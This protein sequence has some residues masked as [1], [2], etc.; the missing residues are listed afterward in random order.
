MISRPR[1]LKII[2]PLGIISSFTPAVLANESEV[3]YGRDIRPILSD[4]CFFCHGPDPETREEGLR[5]DIREEALKGKA[6]VPGHPEKSALIKLINT[7]D[8]EKIM[9]P[10]KSHKKLSE[11]EKKLLSDWIKAGAEYEPHWAYQPLEMHKS[12]DKESIDSLVENR[13]KKKG[14]SFSEPAPAAT[15]LRRLHFDLTGLPPTPAEVVAFTEAHKKDPQQAVKDTAEKLLASPHFGERMAVKWLDA[16]RYADTVGYHGDQSRDASPFRD[17]VINSFN[18]DLPY[19]QF[20][21][22]QIAGDLLPD[23]TLT[24]QV[25][26]AYNRINQISE[27][28]GIQDEEYIAKYQAERV[29]TTSAA[30]L[31]STLACAECHDH[32]FDPFTAKDFYSFAAYFSDILEKGAWNNNGSYQED[33]KKYKKEGVLFSNYGPYLKVPD[34]ASGESYA[35]IEK[36]LADLSNTHLKAYP[37][38]ENAFQAWLTGLRQKPEKAN[39]VDVPFITSTLASKSQVKARKSNATFSY[40]TAD[41]GPVRS[42]SHSRKQAS[43]GSLTQHIF[44]PAEPIQIKAGEMLYAWV[45]LDPKSPPGSVMLQFYK[46]NEGWDHRAYWGENTIPYGKF[47][48]GAAYHKAGSLPQLGNWVRLEVSPKDL[49]LQPGTRVT[50]LAYT[51]DKGTV[52]WGSAGKKVSDQA[53]ILANMPAD[54]RKLINDPKSGNTLRGKAD[55]YQ[56]FLISTPAKTQQ[57]KEI[58]ALHAKTSQTT[59]KFRQVPATISAKRRVVRL[60][61]RGNWTDKSGPIVQ[62]AP[63]EFLTNGKKIGTSRLDLARWIAS[64]DNP[65]TARVFVNRVWSQFFGTGLSKSDGDFGL[66]GEY[67]SNPELLDWL[68]AEFIS[69]DWSVKELVRTIVRSKTYQQSSTPGGEFIKRDPKNRLLARQTQLRLPAELVRDNALAVSGLLNPEIGGASVYPYQP[70]GYYQ[71]LNF[72]KRQYPTSYGKDL[73]RRGIYTHWQRSF[74]HPMMKNFDAPSREECTT[75]RSE[76]NTPLQALTLLN[77]PTFTEAARALATKLLLQSKE[78][79]VQRA[80]MHSLSRKATEAEFKILSELYHTEL[81]RFQADPKA[82]ADFISIGKSPVAKD[83]PAAELAAATSLTRTILNLHETITRY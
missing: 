52:Y 4:K 72:P 16:V 19:D 18:K 34:Q 57:Q 11:R 27:E 36:R 6:F 9:P 47:D 14:M 58:Q 82:A 68:A 41:Q 8:E 75:G 31:G 13:L 80:M 26:A 76:A 28:G 65:L 78:D 64:P 20:I 66:Q 67:P 56:Y 51:Q 69:N 22:E 44:T 23:A 61:P 43:K 15:L 79:L 81:K 70:A 54:I 46:E 5:L 29:R 63:P 25:A 39:A 83:I 62:P 38:S 74:L 32:K 73:Y 2:A 12:D 1:I 40:T 7:T 59:A 33:I 3:S 35:Q 60:L 77:D 53:R 21:I 10:P 49:G 24:Q 71:H 45:Y 50:Q 48:G 17:Y 30:F 37:N 42:G 55:L